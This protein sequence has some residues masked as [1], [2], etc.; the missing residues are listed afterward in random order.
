MNG[1]R[2][3]RRGSGTKERDL[4]RKKPRAMTGKAANSKRKKNV[5]N[6]GTL[7]RVGVALL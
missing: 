2:K 6:N 7:G 3:L 1:G 4:K 5:S